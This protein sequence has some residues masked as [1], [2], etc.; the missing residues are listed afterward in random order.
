MTKTKS[1]A[2]AGLFIEGRGYIEA[3]NRWTEG[4]VG[5]V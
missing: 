1:P 3:F 2:F 4:S 5:M